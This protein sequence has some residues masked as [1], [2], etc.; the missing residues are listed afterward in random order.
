MAGSPEKD[1]G[2]MF[3]RRLHITNIPF[4][5][6]ELDLERLFRP[7]GEVEAVQIIYNER[8]SKGYGFVTMQA[9]EDAVN[10]RNNI[11]NAEVGGRIVS[12]NRALPK[13]KMVKQSEE[14]VGNRCVL[15]GASA[16]SNLDLIRAETKLAEAQYAVL[17]IKHQLQLSEKN[18][19]DNIDSPSLPQHL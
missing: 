16:A 1:D 8:G 14:L 12:V 4:H 3:D 19:P 17:S 9:G 18:N 6:R 5:Y 13:T 10:A 7:F 15:C 11:N 2:E